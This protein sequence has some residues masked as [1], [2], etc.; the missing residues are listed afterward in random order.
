MNAIAVLLTMT[1]V[2]EMTGIPVNTL[3][4]YRHLGNKGP[5]SALIGS[6]I[7]YRE[8]DVLA[9]INEQFEEAK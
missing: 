3:R 2:S 7:M 4:Y 9:W 1:E 8:Q 6:R 5:R